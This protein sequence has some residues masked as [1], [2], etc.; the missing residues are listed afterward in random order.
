MSPSDDGQQAAA[1]VTESSWRRP[2]GTSGPPR[3]PERD[4]R[5][6]TAALELLLEGGYPAL[7]MDKAAA[8]ARVGKATVY[9][10]WQ[11]RAELAA[12]TLEF[13]GLTEQPV[14]L[15]D[16]ES[17]RDDLIETIRQIIGPPESAR[18]SLVGALIETARHEPQLCHVIR[19]RF[20]TRLQGSL[21]EVLARASDQHELP[22]RGH[23]SGMDVAAAVALVVHWELIGERPLDRAAIAVIVDRVLLPLARSTGRP[24]G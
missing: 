17:L 8:R 7:T 21:E 15:A 13:V 22:S 3:D 20:I 12:D 5:I 14:P 11:S 6:L 24:A 4:V 16:S 2:R 9:R 1:V 19:Q 10:R 18:Q 23:G